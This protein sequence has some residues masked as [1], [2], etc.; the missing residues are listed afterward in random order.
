MLGGEELDRVLGRHYGAVKE[1]SN[2]QLYLVHS[3]AQVNLFAHE[4][5]QHFQASQP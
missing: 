2:L 1:L 3:M 5:Q 4:S